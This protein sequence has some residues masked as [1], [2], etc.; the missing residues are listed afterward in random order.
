MSNVVAWKTVRLWLTAAGKQK[1]NVA[2]KGKMLWLMAA[3]LLPPLHKL[4]T[5]TY[6]ITQ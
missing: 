3:C 6:N 4:T 1:T 5:A 2:W